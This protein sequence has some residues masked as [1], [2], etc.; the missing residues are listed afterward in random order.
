MYYDG[1]D[2]LVFLFNCIFCVEIDLG[3]GYVG[4]MRIDMEFI[5]GWVL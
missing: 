5:F 1:R 4:W 2:L 3:I